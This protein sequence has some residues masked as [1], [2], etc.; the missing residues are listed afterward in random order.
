METHKTKCFKTWKVSQ[1]SQV[2]LVTWD[3][4][5]LVAKTRCLIKTFN[6]VWKVNNL[7][8]ALSSQMTG[9]TQRA[10]LMRSIRVSLMI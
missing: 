2:N 4:V 6:L 5:M 9:K 1:Q 7:T 10:H 3:K 8:R